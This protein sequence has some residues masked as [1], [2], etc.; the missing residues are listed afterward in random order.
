[1]DTQIEALFKSTALSV[2]LVAAV[3]RKQ[4]GHQVA[5]DAM[6]YLNAVLSTVHQSQANDIDTVFS[7]HEVPNSLMDENDKTLSSACIQ[8]L[9][10]CAKTYALLNRGDASYAAIS[11]L[12]AK[13]FTGLAVGR[14]M[15]DQVELKKLAESESQKLLAS[16][17]SKT[18]RKG[19]IAKNAAHAKAQEKLIGIW[20]SDVYKTRTKC[21]ESELSALIVFC[22]KPIAYRTAYGWLTGVKKV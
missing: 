11:A 17:R 9:A 22:G 13:Y 6:Q 5:D 1:M 15:I 2:T 10:Y 12:E 4:R 14:S 3:L 18:A 7:G 8:A 16:A 20:R 21:V 19:G